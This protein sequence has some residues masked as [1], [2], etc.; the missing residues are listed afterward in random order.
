[1]FYVFGEM[2]LFLIMG[3]TEDGGDGRDESPYSWKVDGNRV[4]LG[5][6]QTQFYRTFQDP[7]VDRSVTSDLR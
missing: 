3:T 6:G 4:G 1:M 7:R 5:V 2:T